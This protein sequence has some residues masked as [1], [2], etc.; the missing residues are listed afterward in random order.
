MAPVEPTGGVFS[1]PPVSRR[2]L[3]EPAPLPWIASRPYYAWLV[4]GT[5]CI[6]AFMGQLDASIA[7]LVL[8]TLETVFVAPLSSVEWV[9]LAYLL[10]LA[11]L[12]APVGRLADIAGRKLLYTLGFFVFVV[13]SALCGAAPNLP[14]LL[15]S[16]VLQAV[17]AAFLQANSV[18]IVTAAAGPGRRGKAIGIQ[19]TA[20]A[21][22][23]SVGP[24]LGGLL[25]SA[26]GW[27][28]VFF[29]NVPAGI[30]GIV[31]G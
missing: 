29:I 17:G 3:E 28:W 20:Q 27:R 16:R 26:F 21:I 23:L 11:A 10:S 12:L 7:Q 1:R 18:A 19:G 15:G 31:A 9:A 25:I 6:G 24:A 14:V 13:G 30:V 8:P 2:R 4:V 5:V 22:G